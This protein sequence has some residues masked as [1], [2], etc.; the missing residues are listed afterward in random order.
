VSGEDGRFSLA[1][2]R[3]GMWTVTVHAAGFVPVRKYL[4]P[5]LEPVSLP[6]AA[7]VS[8]AGLRV[9]IEDADGR[10]VPGARILG[11]AV[12]ASPFWM[13]EVPWIQ[14]DGPARVYAELELDGTFRLLDL[15]PGV[16]TVTAKLETEDGETREVKRQVTVREGDGDIDLTMDLALDPQDRR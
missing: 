14:A 1:A 9:R 5:L 8:D 11:E 13:G 3:A 12:E 7:L 4:L 15:D 6:D 2:P 10:P 16:W